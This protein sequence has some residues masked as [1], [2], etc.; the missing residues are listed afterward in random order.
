MLSQP[1]GATISTIM[2]KTGWQRHSVRGF[3]AGVVRKKLRLALHSEKKEGA[4][5]IYRIVASKAQTSSDRP[6]KDTT[7]RKVTKSAQLSA[8][9]RAH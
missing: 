9:S 1:Q 6:A 5:R 7:A 2:E 3:F 8:G 4:D